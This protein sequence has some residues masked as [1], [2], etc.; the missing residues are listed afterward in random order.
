[1]GRLRPRRAWGGYGLVVQDWWDGPTRHENV[2]CQNV[3]EE[4]DETVLKR[5]NKTY[6]IFDL[7]SADGYSQHF[8]FRVSDLEKEMERDDSPYVAIMTLCEA[9]APGFGVSVYERTGTI[10]EAWRRE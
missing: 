10:A 4:G 8:E 9:Q 6:V 7:V 1:M 2:S 3:R 5:A